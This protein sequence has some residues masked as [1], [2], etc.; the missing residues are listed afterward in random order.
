MNQYTI[1]VMI[2]VI[3]VIGIT[4][5]TIDFFFPSKEII[6]GVHKINKT[7]TDTGYAEYIYEDFPETQET[8]QYEILLDPTE[9][10]VKEKSHIEFGS[11][12]F[13]NDNFIIEMEDID[14]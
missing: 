6:Y 11:S 2:I 12:V 4:C 1:P 14:D 8:Q 3:W 13:D 5:I 10:D 7:D 9:L